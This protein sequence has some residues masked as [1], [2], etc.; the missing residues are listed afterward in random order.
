LAAC[1]GLAIGRSSLTRNKALEKKFNQVV[2]LPQKPQAFTLRRVSSGLATLATVSLKISS[3]YFATQE[4]HT[5]WLKSH[6][7][8]S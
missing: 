5:L 4:I 3:G 8:S 2:T 7:I 6:V 1:S